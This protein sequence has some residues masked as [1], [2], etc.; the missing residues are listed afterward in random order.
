VKTFELFIAS[1][2]L[3]ARRKHTMVSVI[4]VISVLGVAA[5]VMA[6]VIAMAVTTGFRN[7]LQRSLLGAT[8]HINVVPKVP[9]EGIED[10][11]SLMAHLRKYPH[12]T[13]AAPALYS[14]VLI[15]GAVNS[16]AGEL[17]GIDV[18]AELAISAILRNLKEGSLDRLRDPNANPPGIILGKQLVDDTGIRVNNRIRVLAPEGGDIN[19]MF[20]GP[21]PTARPFKVTGVF[22]SGFYEIDDGYAYTSIAAVQKML[23]TEDEVN[24]IELKVDDLNRAPEIA[25]ELGKVLGPHLTATSWQEQNRRLFDAMRGEEVVTV[26]II[27]LIELVAALNILIVLVMMVM[28]KYRD[29]AILMS[30]GARRQQIRAI[31]M[32]QGVLIGVVG[33]VIG[34]ALGYTLCYFAEKYKWIRIDESVYAF[35]YVPFETHWGHAIWIAAAAILISFLATLYPARNATRIAPAEVLR[36]E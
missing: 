29:I 20:A 4:T 5:G 13:A 8:A 6:L 11:R 25:E 22:Q 3:R 35:S 32:L 36:Y 18:D 26:I 31:F 7:Q 16:K 34:L 30:M 27:G 10:W 1:R 19:P 15:A 33:S 21:V 17:K 2:Y 14:P 28:E 24:A 9:G 12:V 23:G